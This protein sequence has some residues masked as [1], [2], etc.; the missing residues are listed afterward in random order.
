MKAR[1]QKILT[2]G[3][4]RVEAPQM[5]IVGE[6][7]QVKKNL[8]YSKQNMIFFYRQQQEKMID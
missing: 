8:S 3:Y 1:F 5:E 2:A 7:V 4:E 6:R